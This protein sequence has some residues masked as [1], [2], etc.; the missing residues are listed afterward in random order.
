M[1]ALQG[2]G[3]A[4][5]WTLSN[6]DVVRHVTRRGGGSTGR[7]RARA[8]LLPLL[9]LPGQVFL[10][11][12]EELGLEEVDVP[13]E[14]RQDPLYINTRVQNPG[15]DGFRVPLPWIR[16]QPNSGFSVVAP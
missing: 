1:D 12:G 2:P 3:V 11:E 6:H 9:G 13:P 16:G 8:A 7:Q 10:Y 5:S 14:A 4:P 15:R